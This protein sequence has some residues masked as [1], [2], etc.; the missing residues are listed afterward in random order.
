MQRLLFLCHP[1]FQIHPMLLAKK[2]FY[3]VPLIYTL[4]QCL[5]PQQIL[6]LQYSLH[7]KYFLFKNNIIMNTPICYNNSSKPTKIRF[8]SSLSIPNSNKPAS[9]HV[10][11][12]Q[13]QLAIQLTK[14]LYEQCSPENGSTMSPVYGI[15][16]GS[17]LS[18]I[19]MVRFQIV[20]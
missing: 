19:V 17:N 14:Q 16:H 11:I 20:E 5:K 13:M 18:S 8:L 3:F 15:W 12:Q 9:K 1:F 2:I 6:C 4:Q 10:N 7:K